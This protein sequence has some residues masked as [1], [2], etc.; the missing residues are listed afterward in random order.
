MIKKLAEQLVECGYAI[1]L[2]EVPYGLTKELTTYEVCVTGGWWQSVNPYGHEPHSQA[3]R[4]ALQHYR[5]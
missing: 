3:Q 4:E 5:Q 1:D 2:R